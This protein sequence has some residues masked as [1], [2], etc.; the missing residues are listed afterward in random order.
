MNGNGEY[1]AAYAVYA[2][3]KK[4]EIKHSTGEIGKKVPR[5]TRSIEILPTCQT[6]FIRFS[7]AAL[8]KILFFGSNPL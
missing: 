1:I 2:R 4:R 8:V 6:I 5:S 7:L 3:V